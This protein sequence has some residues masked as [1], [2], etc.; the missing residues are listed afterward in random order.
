MEVSCSN[1][2]AFLEIFIKVPKIGITNGKLK[3]AISV[4]LL[5]ALEAMA[6]I[7]VNVIEKPTLPKNKAAQNIVVFLTGFS[8]TT[9]MAAYDKLTNKNSNPIL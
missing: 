8:A 1:A 3:I 6:L 5:S 4:A 2:R 9:V 7:K